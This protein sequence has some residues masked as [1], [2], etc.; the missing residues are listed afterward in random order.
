MDIGYTVGC[1]VALTGTGIQEPQTVVLFT[2]G[3]VAM[4]EETQLSVLLSGSHV[5]AH[6]AEFD[7][8]LVA[9]GGKDPYTLQL[10][11]TALRSPGEHTVAVSA[12]TVHRNM[13]KFLLQLESIGIVI[14]QVENGSGHFPVNGD[15]HIFHVSVGI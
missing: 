7:I 15:T 12:Y 9:V 8:L 4:A 14:S 10:F 1:P 5:K 2:Q 6:M 3:L 11:Y 13:G